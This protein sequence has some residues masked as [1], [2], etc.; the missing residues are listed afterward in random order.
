MANKKKNYLCGRMS[1]KLQESCQVALKDMI[2]HQHSLAHD[3]VTVG[4]REISSLA[5][6]LQIALERL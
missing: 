5:P 1:Q 3:N 4:S 2:M 6:D